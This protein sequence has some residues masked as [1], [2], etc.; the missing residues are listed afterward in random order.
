MQADCSQTSYNKMR[1]YLNLYKTLL[2]V[3][4]ISRRKLKINLTFFYEIR[5]S[6]AKPGKMRGLFDRSVVRSFV[7]S[8]G[9]WSVSYILQ[10]KALIHQQN[11]FS[12]LGGCT[13]TGTG[14]NQLRRR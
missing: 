13:K 9:R 2:R 3:A 1:R 14:R 7:C 8:V 11:Y 12:H 10:M 4:G 5:K 6:I